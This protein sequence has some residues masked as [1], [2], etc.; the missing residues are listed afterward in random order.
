[1]E[2]RAERRAKKRLKID[3]Q[4]LFVRELGSSDIEP[5]EVRNLS[6]GGA[7]VV[8]DIALPVGV[9]L[10]VGFFVDGPESSPLITRARVAWAKALKHAH[11][12]GLSFVAS[13][14][15]QRHSVETL[16]DFIAARRRQ[17]IAN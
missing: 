11:A 15:A 1:M 17:A 16:R 2:A 5:A 13:G 6:D 12:M 7:C 3:L 8:A 14:P 9:E 4:A 10:Y